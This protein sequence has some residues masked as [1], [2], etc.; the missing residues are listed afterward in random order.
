MSRWL[1][2]VSFVS[3]VPRKWQLA[4]LAASVWF[5]LVTVASAG[6]TGDPSEFSLCPL[7]FA[8]PADSQTG[9]LCS[10]SETTGGQLTIGSSTVPISS[11]PDTVDL[12]AYSNTGAGFLGPEVIVTPINGE[13]FGGPAQVVPGGLLGLSGLLAPLSQPTDPINGVTASIELAGPTTPATVVDPTATMA[14]FCATGPLGSCDGS[15]SPYSVVTVPIKV[16]L[17]NDAVLGPTC[18]IGSNASPIV[19]NLVETPTSQ[20]VTSSGGPGE[21]RSSAPAWRWRILL[22]PSREPT[23]VGFLGRST[24]TRPS[25]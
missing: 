1:N 17:H 8:V 11:N 22:S 6:V 18:Y 25:T 14:F 7:S 24:S 10:H 19:L 4:A 20:P 16:H 15:P 23:A 9:L 5:A 3:S 13:V 2:L 21:T 12:G